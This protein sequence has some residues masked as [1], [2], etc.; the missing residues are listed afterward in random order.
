MRT[1]IL[2]ADDH[3]IVR[4]GLRAL[5]EREGFDVQAEAADGR[6]AVRLARDLSPHVALLDL[7]MPLLNGLDAA[8]EIR[9]ASP[10]TKRILLTMY[11]E[12]SYVIEAIRA[13]INGYVLKTQAVAD[14]AQ[15]TRE[16]CQGRVYLSPGISRAVIEAYI[17]RTEHPP[18]PLSRR[19]RE[20]LQLVAEGKTS[21]EI[22]HLLGVT[23]K[24]AEVHRVRIMKKLGIQGTAALVR[25]AIRRGVVRP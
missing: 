12:D 8:R 11:T 20:V 21:K 25:Y 5:L 14:L 19:E 22:A 17:D 23:T 16:V 7:V 15:A 24:T 9:R 4:E 18:D 3:P 2:L 13:G 6:E 1:R 10:R